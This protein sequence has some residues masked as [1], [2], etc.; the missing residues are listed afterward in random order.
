MKAMIFAAGYGKRLLPLTQT[1]PKPLVKIR[2]K[3]ALDW[4]IQQLQHYHI[5]EAIINVHYLADRIIH[6]LKQH[7][8]NFKVTVSHEET[9]LGT[10]GGL[11]KTVDYWND[12][13]F[14]LCNSDI[15][16]TADLND[17]FAFHS[18]QQAMATLA[19]N[20][21]VS[22]SM[23][24]IDEAKN[25]VG[26]RQEKTDKLVV[27]PK[28]KIEP[29]GFCGLHVINSK[30]FR[31]FGHPAEFSIIDEYLKLITK[32]IKIKTWEIGNVYW[33]DIGSK[34]GLENANKHFP[35]YGF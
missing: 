28:G 9:I 17:F 22:D 11:F 32:G 14:Y 4:I 6:H 5:N 26:I 25:L 3:T 18:N 19:V 8:S 27:Q 16:C 12:E 24:L 7:Q 21:E 33:I 34:E 10:G 29:V 20:Y 30:I 23:L 35:G 2:D 1:I 15:L 31:Y 13:D